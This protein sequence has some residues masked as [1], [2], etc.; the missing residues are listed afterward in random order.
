MA[1]PGFLVG[2]TSFDRYLPWLYPLYYTLLFVSR[3][4]DDDKVCLE[5]YGIKWTE[6]MAAVPCRIVPGVW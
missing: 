1:L 3:Q 4:I 6:Y 2:S 5:K